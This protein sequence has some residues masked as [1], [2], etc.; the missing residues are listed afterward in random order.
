M[1][2]VIQS[3]PVFAS[4]TSG[5]LLHDDE[6]GQA[7]ISPGR[8]IPRWLVLVLPYPATS[9][10]PSRY[11]YAAPSPCA[12]QVSPSTWVACFLY[13]PLVEARSALW[14]NECLT[15]YSESEEMLS[16]ETGPPR[17]FWVIHHPML[18]LDSKTVITQTLRAFL[19]LTFDSLY[20][21]LTR[22]PFRGFTNPSDAWIA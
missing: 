9:I 16:F 3:A 20:F 1:T 18:M 6:N 13:L 14:L 4:F 15:R 2:W 8:S 22:A 19:L 12:R 21:F 7:Q 10:N 5:L 17:F 11:V